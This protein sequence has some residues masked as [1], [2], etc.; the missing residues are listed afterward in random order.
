MEQVGMEIRNFSP[1]TNAQRYLLIR[2]IQLQMEIM[3]TRCM[4]VEQ[5]QSTI[6]AL[7]LSA[8]VFWLMLLSVTYGRRR[9]FER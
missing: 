1:L 2:A 9:F 3:G 6:P 8:I 7:F 5:Q 4:V